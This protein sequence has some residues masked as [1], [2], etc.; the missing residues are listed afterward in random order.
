MCRH[1]AASTR[2]TATARF[3]ATGRLLLFLVL[4]L[5]A[6]PAAASAQR[7]AST[8]ALRRLDPPRAMFVHPEDGR[9]LAGHVLAYGP[10]GLEIRSRDDRHH[11]LAWSDFAPS[12]VERVYRRLLSRAEQPAPLLLELAE[13]LYGLEGPD[14]PRAERALRTAVRL[15]ESLEPRA[16]ALRDAA[17]ETAERSD[18]GDDD[19][20]GATDDPND[21][22]HGSTHAPR[23]VGGQQARYWG[24]LSEQVVA[25]SIASRKRF[26][27]DA[28]RKL[29]HALALYETEYFLFYSDL[30]A[31]EARRWAGLL[32]RMYERLAELFAIEP[33]DNIFRG[34]ALILVF[35]R[36]AD[37]HRFQSQIHGTSSVGSIGLCHGFGDG[38]VHIAFFRQ[39]NQWRFA[40][41]LVH[42]AVHGFLHR[43]KTPV[44]VP[45]WVNEGLAEYIAGRLV[46][47]SDVRELRIEHARHKLRE[48]KTFAGMFHAAPIEGWQYGAAL[49]LTEFMIA[50]S[51]RRYADFVEGIKQGLTWEQS[52]EQRY[53]APLDRILDAYRHAHDLP[54]LAP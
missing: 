50:Q 16:E 4:A 22:G 33:E 46:P 15:D 41:V 12:E 48:F 25:E 1:A 5:A 7:E 2:R 42:E 28:Q 34:K 40:H 38:H 31:G 39:E 53:G 6:L 52:L 43:Y 9:R 29:D 11:E 36:E 51:T 14:S 10:G 20:E 8:A 37:Y 47:Q 32:D 54:E 27:Q 49:D 19:A 17:R 18:P 45:S 23:I 35:R 3:G 44:H 21:T 13:V 30:P 26:A 24:E